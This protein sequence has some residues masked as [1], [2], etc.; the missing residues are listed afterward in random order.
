MNCPYP[1]FMPTKIL[2][3]RK[4]TPMH[5]SLSTIHYKQFTLHCLDSLSCRFFILG[6]PQN[7]TAAVLIQT[8]AV[9]EDVSKMGTSARFGSLNRRGTKAGAHPQNPKSPT[10]LEILRLSQI[11]LINFFGNYGIKWIAAASTEPT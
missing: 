5:F 10:R 8:H 2:L 11:R 3:D 7:K 4:A 1:I 6:E 9:G